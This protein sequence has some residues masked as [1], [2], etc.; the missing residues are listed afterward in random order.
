MAPLEL[1]LVEVVGHVVE[2]VRRTPAG[3][4]SG[5]REHRQQLESGAVQR[6]RRGVVGRPQLAGK[7]VA[8]RAI[9][10]HACS[11]SCHGVVKRG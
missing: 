1:V 10:T 4:G 6:E 8:P 7:P 5:A 3:P 2:P 11:W 9:V